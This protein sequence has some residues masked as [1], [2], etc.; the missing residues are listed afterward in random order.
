MTIDCQPLVGGNKM[1]S[2]VPLNFFKFLPLS[3]EHVDRCPHGDDPGLL[4]VT[5]SEHRDL[6]WCYVGRAETSL[7]ELVKSIIDNP[8]PL[9]DALEG[10][11]CFATTVVRD[12]A[13]RVAAESYL[14]KELTPCH[15]QGTPPVPAGVDCKLKFYGA[16]IGRPDYT[17]KH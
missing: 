12:P 1:N 8:G 6:H 11:A 3:A 14:V 4:L 10:G 17:P 2:V 15:N 9:K 7:R 5:A 13:D 16:A